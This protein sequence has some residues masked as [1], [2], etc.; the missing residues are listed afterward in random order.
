MPGMTYSRQRHLANVLIFAT[1][2]VFVG[3]GT[4]ILEVS[5]VFTQAVVDFLK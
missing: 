1:A 4:L 5:N 3:T 2:L